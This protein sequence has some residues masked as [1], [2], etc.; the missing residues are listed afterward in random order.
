MNT[1]QVQQPKQAEHE[2]FLRVIAD[3]LSRFLHRFRFVLWGVLGAA[4]VFLVGWFGWAEINRR[5]SADATLRAEQAQ[6]VYD[7]WTAETDASKKTG[8]QK[9]LAARLDAL[10]ARHGRLYGTQRALLLR[11]DMN[12]GLA[13]WDA[14]AADYR[15]LARRFPSSYL[16]PIALF[17]A[18]VSLEEKA[19]TA[20]A[21]AAYTEVV[22]RFKGS[23]VAPRALFALG[24]LAEGAGT[25]D[26]AKTRYEELDTDWPSSEWAKLAKNRLV[27]LKVAGKIQ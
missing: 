20:G 16:A 22:T 4:L 17:N 19:D 24:R 9:D 7:Q 18:G 13:S 14:A 10:V 26:E 27:A 23:A 8:L 25:W 1:M 5:Q 11:A 21:A 3:G 2:G 15:E 12:F 6:K